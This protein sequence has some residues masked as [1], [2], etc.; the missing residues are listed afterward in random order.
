MTLPRRTLLVALA[1]FNLTP[2][3]LGRNRAGLGGVRG[4]PH[5]FSSRAGSGA[6]GDGSCRF[7]HTPHEGGVEGPLWNIVQS[8]AVYRTY[9]TRSG[10]SL[11]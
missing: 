1:L 2:M 5:D 10:W 3:A 7:C 8:G 6:G 4:T 11:G 9:T